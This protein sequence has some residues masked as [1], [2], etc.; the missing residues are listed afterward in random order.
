MLDIGNQL[1]DHCVDVCPRQLLDEENVGMFRVLQGPCVD[2]SEYLGAQLEALTALP[3]HV[4]LNEIVVR[5]RLVELDLL[6]PIVVAFGQTKRS[7]SSESCL[8]G[9]RYANEANDLA[10]TECLCGLEDP[11]K[12]LLIFR[13][14]RRFRA[15]RISCQVLKVRLS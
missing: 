13:V 14:R 15:I 2:Q 1:T 4:T 12:L 6:D 5:G 8:A 9:S 10:R 11:I 7:H 3:G